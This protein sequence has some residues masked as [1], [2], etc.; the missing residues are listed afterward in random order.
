MVHVGQ[1]IEPRRRD[2]AI[3]GGNDRLDRLDAIMWRNSNKPRDYS[4]YVHLT[5]P[6]EKEAR[7]VRIYMNAPLSYQG[8]TFYQASVGQ[9]PGGPPT[10]TLQVVRNPGWIMPYLSCFMVASGMLFHF[11]LNLVRFIDRVL[12]EGRAF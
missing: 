12:I 3:L 6:Q 2:F 4:S 8:E 1:R 10:T 7:D 11:G 5:N 9:E